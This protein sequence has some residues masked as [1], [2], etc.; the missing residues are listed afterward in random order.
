MMYLIM[1]PS[2][3]ISICHRSFLSIAYSIRMRPV[4][5]CGPAFIPKVTITLCSLQVVVCPSSFPYTSHPKGKLVCTCQ[6]QSPQV[7]L[8]DLYTNLFVV[9]CI[10]LF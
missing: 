1:F 3:L 2:V 5:G 10:K 6:R 8:R 4:L 9:Q 7:F